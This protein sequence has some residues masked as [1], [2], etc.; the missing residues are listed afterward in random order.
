M[1]Q[2]P[3]SAPETQ[4]VKQLLKRLAIMFPPKVQGP[5]INEAKVERAMK[6]DKIIQCILKLGVAEGKKRKVLTKQFL[7]YDKNF[8]NVEVAKSDCR[9]HKW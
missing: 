9:C 5:R 4:V 1:L 8:N 6:N 3:S 2:N 7:T